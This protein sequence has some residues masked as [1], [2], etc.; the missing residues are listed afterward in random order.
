MSIA[1][2]CLL[3]LAAGALTT[4]TQWRRIRAPGWKKV[5]Y[6]FTFPLFMMTYIPVTIMALFRKVEW[7]PIQ[8]RAA[9]SI[10]QLK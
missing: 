9:V 1:A 5:A 10:Q 7:K 4:A 3:V 8:H 2:P 6:T